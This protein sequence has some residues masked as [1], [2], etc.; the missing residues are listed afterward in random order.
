MNTLAD[1]LIEARNQAGRSQQSLAD[2]I[3]VTRSV[4]MNLE[5]KNPKRMLQKAPP[6][7]V[8]GAICQELNINKEWLVNGNGPMRAENTMPDVLMKIWQEASDFSPAEW[9]FLFKTIEA[10]K[11]MNREIEQEKQPTQEAPGRR[12]F[13]KPPLDSTIQ[14]AESRKTTKTPG[15]VRDLEK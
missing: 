2:A 4:I 7:I 13:E 9:A 6:D 11:Q 15:T 14:N 5:T 8:I 10:M 1:R 3:G 12:P